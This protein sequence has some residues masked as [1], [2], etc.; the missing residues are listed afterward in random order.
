[1]SK[2]NIKKIKQVEFILVMV[3]S[4][5]L[6][7]YEQRKNTQTSDNMQL[8]TFRNNQLFDAVTSNKNG[9]LYNFLKGYV[10]N[11]SNLHFHTDS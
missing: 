10:D 7:Q 1:M 9:N 8:R 5:P 3:L 11:S 6:S 2:L 4:T